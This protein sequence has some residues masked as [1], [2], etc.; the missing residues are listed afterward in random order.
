MLFVALLA[1]GSLALCQKIEFEI[2]RDR[3]EELIHRGVEYSRAVRKF[4]KVFGHYPNSVEALESTNNIRFL[5]KRY[6]D[7]I[8]GKDFK[9]LHLQDL[10]AYP[11]MAAPSR[12]KDIAPVSE[13]KKRPPGHSGT[14]NS[15]EYTPQETPSNDDPDASVQAV[16]SDSA[17][18]ADATPSEL[19]DSSP[20]PNDTAEASPDGPI[21]GVA[22]MSRAR[23]I[24]E[25]NKKEHY[26]EWQFVYDP[27]T[28]HVGV[29][30]TPNQPL[31][32][33]TQQASSMP[34]DQASFQ[35]SKTASVRPNT[36]TSSNSPR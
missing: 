9:F 33:G 4:V 25:F 12:P 11:G 13:T 6:K 29:L 3:E 27:S 17:T 21:I 16:P 26:D 30:L 14:N 35:S 24:R 10:Q 15:G 31:L 23:S 5:R 1:V 7:P 32:R 28:D 2:R 19:P 8:T 20:D 34:T 22:S 18:E 36:S